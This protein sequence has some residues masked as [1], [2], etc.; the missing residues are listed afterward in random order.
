M[1]YENVNLAVRAAYRPVPKRVLR[2]RA[3]AR[4]RIVEGEPRARLRRYVHEAG[5][6]RDLVAQAQRRD[7]FEE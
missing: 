7:E 1:R 6:G 5:S 3:T 4:P 2:L